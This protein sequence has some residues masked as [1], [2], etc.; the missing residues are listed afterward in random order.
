MRY[1]VS[2]RVKY[3]AIRMGSQEIIVKNSQEFE[4]MSRMV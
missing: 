2:I 1:F 3:K 4:I